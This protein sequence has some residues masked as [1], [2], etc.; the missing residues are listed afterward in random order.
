[1]RKVIDC[2]TDWF[3]I[4][5]PILM[6]LY[7]LYAETFG[8]PLP[9]SYLI[10]RRDFRAYGPFLFILHYIMDRMIFGFL[11]DLVFAVGIC[12]LPIGIP[13]Y[14]CA[15]FYFHV[16]KSITIDIGLTI[17]TI[18]F[19]IYIII[20][21]CRLIDYIYRWLINKYPP[22]ND[23]INAFCSRI[24]LPIIAYGFIYSLIFSYT[25]LKP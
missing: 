13:S 22:L 9:D 17:L 16:T 24:V 7:A 2:L 6:V 11:Q 18:I 3:W 14:I 21:I 19:I 23:Y 5:L 20:E 8:L 1:M 4:E 12:A 10:F 15:L 25:G